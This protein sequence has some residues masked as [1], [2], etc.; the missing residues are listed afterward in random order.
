MGAGAGA[1][2]LAIAAVA[3]PEMHVGKGD[4]SG[5]HEGLFARRIVDYYVDGSYVSESYHESVKCGGLENDC[6]KAQ[7]GVLQVS[8]RPPHTRTRTGFC[9]GRLLPKLCPCSFARVIV[10]N[11]RLWTYAAVATGA[12]TAA[13]ACCTPRRAS[14]RLL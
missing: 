14:V 3:T 11:R 4:E 13:Y 9:D 2:I 5:V 6:D 12:L 1:V 7:C 10:S 8:T